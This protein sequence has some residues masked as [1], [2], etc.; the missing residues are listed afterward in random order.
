MS[1]KTFLC[2][3]LLALLFS[4][5]NA[6]AKPVDLEDDEAAETPAEGAPDAA[7]PA[8]PADADP[9]KDASDVPKGAA[10]DEEALPEESNDE[11]QFLIGA[12]YRLLITP[13]FLINW[14]GVEGGTDI[15]LHGI[16]PEFGYSHK[17]F[18]IFFSPWYADYGMAATPFRMPNDPP[19]TF[20]MFTSHLKVMYL[21]VDL[22]WKQKMT[23]EIDWHVGAGLGIGIVFDN[24]IRNETYW[25]NGVV[26]GDP[27]TGLGECSAPGFASNG[28]PITAA[29]TAS[30]GCPVGGNYGNE[31]G[32]WPVYPWVNFQ[33]GLRWQPHRH[34]VGR[35]DIGLGS[36]GFWF[37]LGADYG[38]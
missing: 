17:N 8:V 32:V 34:F 2:S 20:D 11:G 1:S 33:T 18:E 12:R 30:G 37:G 4:A 31:P 35:L 29:E 23:N 22:A 6:F 13:K 15:V 21:D 36:S 26:T 3:S 14:F 10:A 16:G 19:N 28:L 7:D 25:R 38:I 5:P 9:E 27:Y 24:L